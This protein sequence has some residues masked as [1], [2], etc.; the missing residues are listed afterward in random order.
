M[1][2]GT[3]ALRVGERAGTPVDALATLWH[4]YSSHRSI[5]AQSRA[6]AGIHHPREGNWLPPEY[7]EPDN[8]RAQAAESGAAR[9]DSSESTGA[10]RQQPGRAVRRRERLPQ[11]R[12]VEGRDPDRVRRR[13]GQGPRTGGGRAAGQ[14]GRAGRP[15]VGPAGK[16]FDKALAELG[17]D[18]SAMYVTNAEAFSLR[19]ARQVPPAPQPYAGTCARLPSLAGRR[20]ASDQAGHRRLPGCGRRQ[21]R[22]RLRVRSAA[23]ARD[24]A[25]TAERCAWTVRP[26]WVLRQRDSAARE[27]AYRGF[28]AD[29]ELLVELRS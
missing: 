19:D 23:R 5:R 27:Q 24:V 20:A 28:V 6:V 11:L 13:S 8:G 25:G 14:R 9:P 3:S 22:I 16:L 29:L 21:G 10:H 26:S 7:E 1:H 2:P 15:F 17:L 12:A 4:R 18:R